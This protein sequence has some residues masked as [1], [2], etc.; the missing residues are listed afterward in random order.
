M[1]C[2]PVERFTSRQSLPWVTMSNT[3]GMAGLG[4]RARAL[5]DQLARLGV[6]RI[7]AFEDMPFPPPWWN[8]DGRGPLSVLLRWTDRKVDGDRP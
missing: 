6:S 8:H 1:N 5:G 3:V 7:V 2:S 4:T